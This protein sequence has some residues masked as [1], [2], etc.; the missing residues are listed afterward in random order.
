MRSRSSTRAVP[1]SRIFA[2]GLIFFASAIASARPWAEHTGRLSMMSK[3]IESKEHEIQSLIQTKR[4]T[5]DAKKVAEL[6]R[7][8]ADQHKAML[9]LH[10]DYEEERQH[11][12][13][14][15]PERNDTLERVYVRH[16]VRSIEDME[17]ELG[18][19]GRLDRLKARVLAVFPIPDHK[20]EPKFKRTE[21]RK[22]ASVDD[23]D[24][25]EKIH[26]VK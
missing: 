5:R 14:E 4:E 23:E 2:A 22:P 18:L 21:V 26:L 15:H 9:K 19:D 8:I 10:K 24:A 13:F 17:S 11:V 20:E 6:I 3:Q 25:P 1:F 16:Q 7:Q 12:R